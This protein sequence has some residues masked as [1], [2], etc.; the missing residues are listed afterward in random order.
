MMVISDSPASRWGESEHR[1]GRRLYPR[2]QTVARRRRLGLTLALICSTMSCK[3]ECSSAS[4]SIRGQVQIKLQI[5]I[6]L[7]EEH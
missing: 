3:L 4:V 2:G 5:I 1:R 7:K 6:S